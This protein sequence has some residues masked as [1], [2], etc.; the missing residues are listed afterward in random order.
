MLSEWVISVVGLNTHSLSTA[1]DAEVLEDGN[2]RDMAPSRTWQRKKV[3][4][5]HFEVRSPTW[6]HYV[7]HNLKVPGYTAALKIAAK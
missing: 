2:P 4:K 7:I 1:T 6:S 3:K 5:R